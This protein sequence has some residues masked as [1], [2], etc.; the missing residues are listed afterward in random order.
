VLGASPRSGQLKRTGPEARPVNVR[1]TSL[2]CQPL[3]L[4]SGPAQRPR[5]RLVNAP[6]LRPPP[7][8]P[9][10]PATCHGGRPQ[11]FS[12]RRLRRNRAVVGRSS[13]TRARAQIAT[14]Q[15][16]GTD[17]REEHDER[18][19]TRP[20]TSA[21]AVVDVRRGSAP[22]DRPTEQSAPEARCAPETAGFRCG[23]VAVRA[24]ADAR[25]RR[26]LVMRRPA[27]SSSRWLRFSSLV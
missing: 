14:T 13:S 2:T 10:R 23:G 5:F 27:S 19:S 4:P 26:R 9:R 7:A 12:R 11:R 3:L 1:A 25:R 6:H 15:T 17:E 16:T 22:A 20:R 21:V 8:A 18:V 24:R